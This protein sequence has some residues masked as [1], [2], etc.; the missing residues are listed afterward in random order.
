MLW[1]LCSVWVDSV[2]VDQLRLLNCWLPPGRVISIPSFDCTVIYIMIVISI[3]H[4][5]SSSVEIMN[6]NSQFK[7]ALSLR[8]RERAWKLSQLVSWHVRCCKTIILTIEER[9]ELVHKDGH[10]S[11]EAEKEGDGCGRGEEEA[12]WTANRSK[13]TADR[14]I[15]CT[16][17]LRG[18]S[19][20]L[21]IRRCG[22]CCCCRR[23][24]L[25][26][27]LCLCLL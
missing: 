23:C 3:I 14:E 7:R 26:G 1:S 4:M 18:S 21:F 11:V 22:C 16:H 19:P 27:L 24:L 2:W 25:F 12:E 15:S 20:D 9:I 17:L 5:W 10:N 6:I 8:S 13:C